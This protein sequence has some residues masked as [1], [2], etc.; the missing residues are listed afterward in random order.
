MTLAPGARLGPYEVSSLVGSGGMG[1]VYRARDPRLGR[2]VAI[3][4]LPAGFSTDSDRLRRFELEARAAAA[5][6][7]TNILAVHDIGTHNGSPYIVSE[8]LEGE[9]LRERVNR[10]LLPVRKTVEYAVQIAHG[11]AAA[12]DKGIVHRDLKP[13][14]V[15]LAV[16]GR[17]KILDFG[18]AKLTEARTADS[19]ATAAPTVAAHTEPGIVLGTVGYMSPE[20]VRGQPTDHRTDVFAFG[21][22]LYE[23]LSGR[24]AFHAETVADT[25]T[26][27]LKEDPPDLPASERHIPPALGRIVDRCLEK[28][29]QARF[30]SSGDL[31]FALEALSAQSGVSEAVAS[32][33]GRSRSHARL[34]WMLAALFGLGLVAAASFAAVLYLRPVSDAAPMMRFTLDP[35]DGWNL[36]LGTAPAGS[37]NVAMGPLAVSPDG[38]RIAFIARNR[39]GH[40]LIW[41]RALDAPAAAPLVGTDRAS[42]PFWSPDSRFLGFFAD[43][44]LKRIEVAGGPPT[45]VCDVNG[46]AGGTWNRDGIIVFA[47]IQSPLQKVHAS[48]GIPAPA[49]FLQEAETAH[50]RPVFLPDGRHF[51]FRALE[52]T[53]AGGQGRKIY[54]ASL[55]SGTRTELLLSD[56]TNVSYSQQH[57]LFLRGTTLMAQAFDPDR[58]ALTGE[59][60]PIADEIQTLG[61]PQSGVFSVSQNGVLAYQTGSA[62]HRGQPAW[63]DRTGKS[64]ETIGDP[65]IQWELS[66]SPD[67]KRAAV[68]IFDQSQSTD[69][70]LLDLTR[71]LRTRFTFD[72][73]ND[74]GPVW[75]PDGSRLIFSSNR[76]G[77]YD[78]YQRNASGTGADE[79]LYADRSNK[80]PLSWSPDGRHVLYTG[81][82]KGDDILVLPLTGDRKPIPF[83]ETP[84]S[85]VSGQFSPDG[86]W[87]AYA[88]NESGR[89]DIYVAPFPPTG[90]K[91]MVS[92][93]GGLVPRWRR[94]GAE[95]FYFDG[96]RLIA[97]TVDGRTSAFEVGT[98]RP[99]FEPVSPVRVG[100]TRAFYDV[101]PDGQRFLINMSM[102]T[103]QTSGPPVAVVLNWTAGMRK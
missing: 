56:S 101:S 8:L 12:H 14:N 16:D 7:H 55:D 76:T 54:L 19:G 18:L 35:P 96:A 3:K 62:T 50:T 30:Q 87:I 60:V 15:F 95:I 32:G 64:L 5:L 38:R 57:L 77:I 98:A 11:L 81:F 58:L 6:S 25:M 34:P 68:T 65:G 80:E 73:G 61:S 48:G 49:L 51:L 27:I 23:M 10:G 22:M 28:N 71:G 1:E 45:V 39:Q 84:F 99:L 37:G 47:A 41:I 17:V 82:S 74:R 20:Q 70:W 88:S 83:A 75:A 86:R 4:V 90:G 100:E 102:S 44:K 59:P 43:G 89:Y 97:V 21:A 2:D 85:E 24:R 91:W 79:L 92:R 66:L 46:G 36:A 26:A 63:L 40:A 42:S 13:E 69:I 67:G 72:P 31:A 93:S 33:T 78:I 29:P 94:D 53:T 52:S 9:T 103:E